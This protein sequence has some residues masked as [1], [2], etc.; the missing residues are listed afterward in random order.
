MHV[1]NNFM[2]TVQNKQLMKNIITFYKAVFF[3]KTTNILLGN[4]WRKNQ[5]AIPPV[6]FNKESS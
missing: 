5:T 3:Y 4:D 2:M 6:L 1:H